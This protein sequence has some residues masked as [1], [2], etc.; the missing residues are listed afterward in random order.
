MKSI[1][2]RK[3]W[4]LKMTETTDK[5]A[6]ELLEGIYRNVRMSADSLLDLLPHVQDE[7]LKSD[8]TVQ[9][10]VYEAFSSRAVKEME[11]T[12]ATPAETNPMTRFSAKMGTFWHTL[13]DPSSPHIAQMVLEGTTMGVGNLLR[14]LRDAENAGV[15]EDIL[16]L[17]RDVCA[18]EERAAEDMKAYLK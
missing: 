1:C 4:S 7:K 9:L 6:E 2:E 14:A 3:E 17:A 12:G 18:Y 8:L 13:K 11:N 15:P 10:S 5:T 16:T